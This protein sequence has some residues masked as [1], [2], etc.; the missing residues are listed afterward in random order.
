MVLFVLKE[1]PKKNGVLLVSI[2]R[3]RLRFKFN[4]LKDSFVQERV[5]SCL[6]V[7]TVHIV[8]QDLPLP[9]SVHQ[10]VLV[11]AMLIM[12][13]LDPLVSLVE[14][15]CIRTHSQVT[16]YALIAHLAMFALVTLQLQHH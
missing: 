14:E 15:A 4:A 3:L 2:A 11:Q 12:A 16:E 9:Y 8:L 10:E 6:N 1:V 5:N 13:I 7:V